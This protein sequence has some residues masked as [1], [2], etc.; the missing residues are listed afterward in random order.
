VTFGE[1]TPE[2]ILERL[3]PDVWAK[4][5]DYAAEDLPEARVL[6]RWGAKLVLLPFL[7]GRSTTR[8][9]KEVALRAV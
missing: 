1:D 5:G 3:R 7:E 4:G 2:A 6:A 9:L 8:L